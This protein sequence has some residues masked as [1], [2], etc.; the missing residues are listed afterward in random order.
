MWFLRGSLHDKTYHSNQRTMSHEETI[1]WK[2]LAIF[3]V[4]NCCERAQSP[5][6]SLQS[7]I[8]GINST[9]THRNRSWQGARSMSNT[10]RSKNVSSDALQPQPVSSVRLLCCAHRHTGGVVALHSLR[11]I[12]NFTDLFCRKAT[13][14]PH[15]PPF[16]PSPLSEAND[17]SLDLGDTI[18]R[19]L[20][21]ASILEKKV[22]CLFQLLPAWKWDWYFHDSE[23]TG[24]P[25]SLKIFCNNPVFFFSQL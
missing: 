11:G 7:S 2:Q 13:S 14:F 16:L 4:P 1:A 20:W 19:R 6:V 5:S 23:I 10:S 8:P 24:T 17:V 15:H 9:G 18:S 3:T 21:Q 12:W 25:P 22:S